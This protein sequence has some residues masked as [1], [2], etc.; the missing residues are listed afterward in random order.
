MSPREHQ[1]LRV[2]LRG[3]LFEHQGRVDHWD[4][5][6]TNGETASESQKFY[7]NLGEL[8]VEG[9]E[10]SNE[11]R[12]KSVAEDTLRELVFQGVLTRSE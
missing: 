8:D 11:F 2:N 3:I 12:E 10:I 5:F 9:A 7:V 6:Q 4:G 1:N